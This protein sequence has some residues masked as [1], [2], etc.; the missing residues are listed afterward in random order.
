MTYHLLSCFF[1]QSWNDACFQAVLQI[2]FFTCDFLHLTI[3]TYP[4]DTRS[5]GRL[6]KEMQQ[7]QQEG[8]FALFLTPP[9]TST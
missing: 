8:R 6:I 1:Q 4:Q 3:H 7:N 2:D 9:G 5:L